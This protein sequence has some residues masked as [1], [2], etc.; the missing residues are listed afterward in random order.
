MDYFDP[1]QQQPIVLV[2][3]HQYNDKGQFVSKIYKSPS[4]CKFFV[5]MNEVADKM[6]M[7]A[8]HTH[9][10]HPMLHVPSPQDITLPPGGFR[11]FFVVEGKAIDGDTPLT[12]RRRGLSTLRDR[13][14]K[15]ECQGHLLRIADKTIITPK[16]L[17][18]RWTLSRILRHLATSHSQTFYRNNRYTY[19]IFENVR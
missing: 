15:K 6:V 13:A 18:K 3:S 12:V 8:L 14:M 16:I 5:K 9:L 2:D 17:G 10:G 1:N 7:V 4:H 19:R 11:F